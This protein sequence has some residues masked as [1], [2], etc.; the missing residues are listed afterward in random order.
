LLT[1]NALVRTNFLYYRTLANIL[2]SNVKTL[3]VRSAMVV[4]HGWLNTM[5][6]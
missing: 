5:A 1:K 4:Q 2:N 6:S 3:Y